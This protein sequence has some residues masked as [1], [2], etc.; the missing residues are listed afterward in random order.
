M[1]RNEL[2]VAFCAFDFPNY[3]NGP[4]SWL[5]RLLPNLRKRG[6]EPEIW[7]F[8]TPGAGP[9]INAMRDLGIGCHVF[10][11]SSTSSEKIEWLIQQGTRFKPDVFIP[12]LCV[13]GMLAAPA[14]RNAGIPTVA[15]LHTDDPFYDEVINDFVTG[16]EC[17]QI[18]GLVCVSQ[19]QMEHVKSP[20]CVS[21]VCIAYGVELPDSVSEPPGDSLRLIYTGRFAQVQKRVR[22]VAKAFARAT[23]EIDGVSATMLGEGEEL[24][25]VRKLLEKYPQADVSLPGA[26]DSNVVY[27]QLLRHHVIVLLSDYEGLPISLLEG[28]ACGLVPLCYQ[29]RSGLDELVIPGETGLIFNDRE[30]GFLTAVRQLKSDPSIWRRLSQGARERVSDHYRSDR[31][32]QDWKDFFVRLLKVAGPRRELR[33]EVHDLPPL[34]SILACEDFRTSEQI[35]DPRFSSS[36]FKLAANI[37][38]HS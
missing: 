30:E 22:D 26:V 29:F 27:Q 6:I 23:S 14:F 21:K 32:A 20:D 35:R 17:D 4:N 24:P 10:P 3:Y 5:K 1:I 8:S 13:A 15:I 37:W 12:N 7:F 38:N 33:L 2:R 31:I 19:W 34:N 25:H 28:M 36:N 18:S 11:W 9:L 16:R